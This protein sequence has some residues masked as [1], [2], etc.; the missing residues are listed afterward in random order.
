M[1][2]YNKKPSISKLNYGV[3]AKFSKSYRS[4]SPGST[5]CNENMYGDLVN[6]K[7]QN[8]QGNS[9]YNENSNHKGDFSQDVLERLLSRKTVIEVANSIRYDLHTKNNK[10]DDNIMGIKHSSNYYGGKIRDKSM[11]KHFHSKNKL[12]N[13]I[14]EKKCLTERP[15]INEY[16]QLDSSKNENSKGA[17]NITRRKPVLNTTRNNTDNKIIASGHRKQPSMSS[18]LMRSFDEDF[19]SYDAELPKEIKEILDTFPN[20]SSNLRLEFFKQIQ[21]KDYSYYEKLQ[22]QQEEND[23]ALPDLRGKLIKIKPEDT[24]RFGIKSQKN[25]N[26]NT[27]LNQ[28]LEN[29]GSKTDTAL[30]LFEKKKNVDALIKKSTISPDLISETNTSEKAQRNHLKKY[31]VSSDRNDTHQS[32]N[33]SPKKN[34][35]P[36][37]LKSTARRLYK[38][39]SQFLNPDTI[40]SP[41][42]NLKSGNKNHV[43]VNKEDFQ[44]NE[45]EF[46]HKKKSLPC[47]VNQ[48][49]DVLSNILNKNVN[50]ERQISNRF[51][52]NSYGVTMVEKNKNLQSKIS[53]DHIDIS[54][55]HINSSSVIRSYSHIS[56]D[57]NQN[58]SKM[59]RIS[60]RD[61]LEKFINKK[62]PPNYYLIPTE[63]NSSITDYNENIP[64]SSFQSPIE[65]ERVARNSDVYITNHQCENKNLHD[66]QSKI[67]NTEDSFPN[68]K[69]RFSGSCNDTERDPKKQH[70]YY[71]RFIKEPI[72]KLLLDKHSDFMEIKDAEL[73]K[74][75]RELYLFLTNSLPDYDLQNKKDAETILNN[76]NLKHCIE[77]LEDSKPQLKFYAN[78]TDKQFMENLQKPIKYRQP[79][80]RLK[81][82]RPSQFIDPNNI[83]D[84]DIEKNSRATSQKAVS[85]KSQF[86]NKNLKVFIE[87]N[88]TADSN[89]NS[90]DRINLSGKKNNVL[91]IQSP[92]KT[93]S[94]NGKKN[95]LLSIE[96]PS[97]TES[98]NKHHHANMEIMEEYKLFRS[99]VRE[100]TGCK[101][102]VHATKDPSEIKHV[103]RKQVYSD[104]NK[105]LDKNQ[106]KMFSKKNN[107]TNISKKAIENPSKNSLLNV[108]QLK[109]S[110]VN[111]RSGTNKTSLL[112]PSITPKN[113][114]SFLNGVKK[115][116][117]FDNL[118]VIECPDKRKI[119]A[120]RQ[121]TDTERKKMQSL[122]IRNHLDSNNLIHTDQLEKQK[123]SKDNNEKSYST[124]YTEESEV[125]DGVL[126]QLELK[127]TKA[128]QKYNHQKKILQSV[129]Y[130]QTDFE[131]AIFKFVD[132][133][134]IYK[135]IFNLRIDSSFLKNRNAIGN[136]IQHHIIN[137]WDVSHVAEFLNEEVSHQ[138]LHEKNMQE[139]TPKMYAYQI[140]K[141]KIF[142]YLDQF[143]EPEIVH[144]GNKPIFDEDQQVRI[145][146][147]NLKKKKNFEYKNVLGEMR[148]RTKLSYETKEKSKVAQFGN[149][150][151]K[152][153]FNSIHSK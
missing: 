98:P 125:E 120:E 39:S 89:M 55:G 142:D 131:K 33:V 91:K 153:R 13:A 44:P 114:N 19:N 62:L 109:S 64:D 63:K 1:A 137:K 105:L 29:N 80:Q 74:N 86:A 106:Q 37:K 67:N 124:I 40:E 151:R 17:N 24:N 97:R 93:E 135:I 102:I 66:A 69:E 47:R 78:N 123:L 130:T 68:L 77:F 60:K 147:E 143:D 152:S 84:L 79:N 71:D 25:L 58:S 82:E 10:P 65:T 27:K 57:Q 113:E 108:P 73:I 134:K 96:S 145:K 3:V 14:F 139:L 144:Y 136:T 103:H 83:I 88:K 92:S 2:E 148:K 38:N 122:C 117:I 127:C 133:D 26:I 90:P 81:R 56:Q 70:L 54:K 12:G 8:R 101:N 11:F 41:R 149:D 119:E 51:S 9:E 43:H 94:P 112:V 32:Y 49:G 107:N 50:I 116:S 61:Y 121:K 100:S 110:F 115:L 48:S 128:V 150:I 7:I 36:T 75:L 15:K 118:P 126:K 87:K 95:N 16:L 104:Q 31:Y 34:S 22:K 85:N 6:D 52:F 45:I 53:N 5:V 132:D 59:C 140:G 146:F 35:S 20:N 72:D 111:V 21:Q 28:Q 76:Y 4:N 138:L 46:I 18:N 42:L 30:N 129:N 99:N 23:K 141:K